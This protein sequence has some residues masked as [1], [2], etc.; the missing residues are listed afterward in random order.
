M[1]PLDCLTKPRPGKCKVRYC[2]KLPRDIGTH[3]KSH[4]L[5]GHHYKM[6]WRFNNPLHAAFDD[7][8]SSARKRRKEFTLTLEQ[9]TALVAPTRYMDEK[10][11][12]RHCL[13]I[14]RIDVTLGYTFENLQVITC[15]ENVL[16][17]NAERRQGFVDAKIRGRNTEEDE[18]DPF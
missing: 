9:F 16:K 14:D 8:R 7:L 17:G 5:C 2:R 13:H 4:Q 11:K 10:G 1:K 12:E 18:V 6:L 15:T 3:P